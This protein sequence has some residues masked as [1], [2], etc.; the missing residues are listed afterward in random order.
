MW[1][2]EEQSLSEL[3]SELGGKVEAAVGAPT[4]LEEMRRP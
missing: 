1:K 2:E 4:V 3:A